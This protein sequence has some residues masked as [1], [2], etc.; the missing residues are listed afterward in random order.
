MTCPGARSGN[1]LGN[2]MDSIRAVVLIKRS[3]PN[4][5]EIINIKTGIHKSVFRILDNIFINS[6]WFLLN[7]IK[8]ISQKF[9]EWN[10]LIFLFDEGLVKFI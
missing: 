3:A 4:T 10:N 8:N 5:V 7:Y 2:V 6:Y 1:S 9:I